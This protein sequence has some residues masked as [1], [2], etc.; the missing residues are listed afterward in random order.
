MY[1]RHTNAL[2]KIFLIVLRTGHKLFHVEHFMI[3]NKYS[4]KDHVLMFHVEHFI[5]R[6]YQ[7]IGEKNNDCS[8]WN[9]LSRESINPLARKLRIVPRGTFLHVG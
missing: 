4:L 7:L 6:I 2:F 1:L 8:T 5:Q 9:I 3:I